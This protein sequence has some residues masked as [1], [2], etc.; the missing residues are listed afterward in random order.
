MRLGFAVKV[1]GRPGLKSN[2]ARRSQS[3]P[4]L[5][6]SLRYLDAILDYLVDAQI[7][8]YRISSEIAPYITHP[9]LPEF[10][11]QLD[12]CREELARIGEKARAQGV[13]LSMH[14]SQYIVLNSPTESVYEASVRDFVY[15]AE[16]L[17]AMGLGPEAVIVTHGGG[18]YGDKPAAIDRFVERY[19]RLPERVRARLVLEN[20]EK[21]YT[22]P[23]IVGIHER[24]GVP[25]V[26]DNLHHAVNNPAG[27]S[28]REA[29]FACVPTWPRGVVPKIHYSSTRTEARLVVRRNRKTGLTTTIETPPLASQHSDCIVAGE[30]FAFVQETAPLEYDVMLEAKQ[31]D[32][33]LLR[34][35]DEL[36]ALGLETR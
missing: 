16:F 20:D 24:T 32:V 3:G 23:D 34:L 8:M 1:L 31:K 5:S 22:A 7:S 9:D 35:R 4:H 19:K 18:V 36:R 26:L 13:R 33:A 11:N 14:P 6:V 10:H 29:A 28:H 12:E 30:F 17:D 15:H 25:L 2:D 21:S 27:L